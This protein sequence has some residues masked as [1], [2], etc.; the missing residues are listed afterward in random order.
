LADFYFG[1]W[2]DF[3]SEFGNDEEA[4]NYV[5]VLLNILSSFIEKK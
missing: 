1:I 2:Q 5:V 3:T 4:H